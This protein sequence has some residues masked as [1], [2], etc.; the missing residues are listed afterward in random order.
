MHGNM[1]VKLDG[2]YL[3]TVSYAK[4]TTEWHCSRPYWNR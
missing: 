4:F 2:R 3:R 1:N